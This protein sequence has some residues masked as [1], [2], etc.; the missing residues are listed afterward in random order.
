[1]N[2]STIIRTKIFEALNGFDYSGKVIPVF[3]EVVNPDASLP[4]VG[5]AEEVYIILQDQQQNPNA[6]QPY[7]DPRF[8]LNITIRVVTKWGLT[9]SKKL[10]ESIGDAILK[11][12]RTDRSGSKIDG[13]SKIEL[14]VSQTI[15]ETTKTNLS[16]SN[17]NILNCIYNG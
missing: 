2:R 3:D 6:V 13:I 12:I 4:S 10:C 17:I 5:G 7:C 16:Y 14:P 9:G 1:M 15:S 8:N 11:L